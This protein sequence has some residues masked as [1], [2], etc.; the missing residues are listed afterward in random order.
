MASEDAPRAAT[1]SGPEFGRRYYVGGREVTA[2]KWREYN[3]LGAPARQ[4]EYR[5]QQGSRRILP[6]YEGV[7]LAVAATLRDGGGTFE[8]GT[9]KAVSKV[10]G[11]QVGTAY[12]LAA[13]TL[14]KSSPAGQLAEYVRSYAHAA[15]PLMKRGDFLGTWID[16]DL[17]F[18]EVCRHV[19]T[20]GEAAALARRHNQAEVWQWDKSLSLPVAPVE[21][22]PPG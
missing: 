3:L 10:N 17:F 13:G 16:G 4:L 12:P 9:L 7:G 6:S 22:A 18:I 20:F 11:Y 21:G 14:L 15:A 2:V 19:A 5:R 1:Y 8:K